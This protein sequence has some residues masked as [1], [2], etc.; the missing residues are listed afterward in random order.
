VSA[1]TFTVHN[2][3]SASL[4]TVT[5]TCSGTYYVTVAGNTDASVEIPDSATS[6]TINGTKIPVGQKT[7]M[8]LAS[9]K[10]VEVLWDNGPVVID[11]DE[12]LM[13]QSDD[14]AQHL[15]AELRARAGDW[16]IRHREFYELA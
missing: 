3:Q 14:D 4:G 10:Q 15:M 8:Q 2:R 9:G 6:I 16:T 13:R 5:V 12:I 1:L 7:Y 11:P